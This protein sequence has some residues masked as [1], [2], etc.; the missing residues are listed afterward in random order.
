MSPRGNNLKRVRGW[1]LQFKV[2][3]GLT[4]SVITGFLLGYFLGGPGL[5]SYL[6]L[7]GAVAGFF[8]GITYL[9]KLAGQEQ[10]GKKGR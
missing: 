2:I 1:L 9:V 6:G 4:F 8:V 5:R 7:A 3:F 10:K